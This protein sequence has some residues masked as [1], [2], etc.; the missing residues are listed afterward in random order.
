MEPYVVEWLSLLARWLHVITG[1]AWIGASFYFI[2]LDNHLTAPKEGDARAH[3]ELWA[4]HGGGFYH[5]QK[6]LL[7]PERLPET[8]HWFKWEA[9]FT[10]ISGML[11][12][13]IVYW[14]GAS[15]YLIDKSVADLTP[16]FA[17]ALSAA[18]LF[19]G[20][21]VYEGLC[22]T[23]LVDRGFA[24]AVSGFFLILLAAWALEQIFSGRAAYLHVGSLLGTIMVANV[25][26]VIMPGQRRMVEAVREGR[27]PEPRYGL[28]GKQRSVHNNYMTLPVVLLMIS[29]HYPMTYSHE[30]GWLVLGVLILASVLIR[31]FF[32][33]RH[34][35]RVVI[36]LPA[37]AAV[38]LAGL[39]VAIA[40]EPALSDPQ[41]KSR[42]AEVSFTH[43]Q[44]VITQRCITC[45]SAH[46]TDRNFPV[47][48]FAVTF[49]TP[50]QI[51]AHAAR[52][53]ERTVV[54]R[55]MPLGN[56]TNITDDERA[57]LAAWFRQGAQTQ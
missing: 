44:A 22:R 20:W 45:H 27:T 7:G 39:G 30:Y 36:A 3:G 12:L 13:A 6:Y 57:L 19:L 14:Y 8:L 48:P 50:V 15:A 38:L 11:L 34:R 33:L 28:Q 32:N 56:S 25:L 17:I 40:P 41:R 53:H 52:I 31:H 35:G 42:R 5:N 43:V 24:F 23:P 29:N 16:S 1:I 26:F 37:A 47:A 49:D 46:P 2:W 21:L 9:Y 10:W 55:T 54:N 4:I 51:K 18:T